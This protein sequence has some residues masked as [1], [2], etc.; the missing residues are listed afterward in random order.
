MRNIKKAVFKIQFD[1]TYLPG[2]TED[3][4]LYQ[5]SFAPLGVSAYGYNQEEAIKNAQIQAEQEL[6]ANSL[7]LKELLS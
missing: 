1:L 6:I 4:D 2:V 3:L 5:A 7:V